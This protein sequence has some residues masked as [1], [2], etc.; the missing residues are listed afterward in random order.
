MAAAR[1]AG[2]QAAS[3][4]TSIPNAKVFRRRATGRR[5]APPSPASVARLRVTQRLP[6]STPI[7][8]EI[9]RAQAALARG[10]DEDHAGHVAAG[11]ADGARQA[12]LARA[13]HDG[14]DQRVHQAEQRHEQ[15]RKLNGLGVGEAVVD[16]RVDLLAD[17][18]VEQDRELVLLE[19]TRSSSVR[20]RTGSEPCLSLTAKPLTSG[21]Q[22][23]HDKVSRDM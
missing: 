16:D 3:S 22:K 15:R 12:D 8:I 17:V 6:S 7:A 14:D 4:V 5:S 21:R 19:S 23:A 18:A 9:K 11:H 1:R 10:L 13:L 2:Y 20:T